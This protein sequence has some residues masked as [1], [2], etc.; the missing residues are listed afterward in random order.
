MSS[1][2]SYETQELIRVL[3]PSADFKSA[4]MI[5]D[6]EGRWDFPQFLFEA[7]APINRI[8]TCKYL[9]DMLGLDAS[10]QY[11]TAV[12]DLIGYVVQDGAFPGPGNP[13]VHLLWVET[14][15]TAFQLPKRWDWKDTSFIAT[16]ISADELDI[17]LLSKRAVQFLEDEV[18]DTENLWQPR[19][20][21]G[22]FSKA[23]AWLKETVE[24]NG[25][26]LT[27]RVRQVQASLTSTVLKAVSTNG[28]FYLKAPSVGANELEMTQALLRL[29]P[30][31]ILQVVA[32]S[33]EL[34]SFISKEFD[35]LLDTDDEEE[36]EA[37]GK[38][39][40]TALGDMQLASLKF[41]ED[42][43]ES[44]FPLLGIPQLIDEIENLEDNKHLDGSF[45]T[46]LREISPLLIAQ[47]RKLEVYNIPLVVTHGD[48]SVSNCG[49][50]KDGTKKMIL[51]DFMYSAI[52]HPFFDFHD[53]EMN[54]EGKDSYFSRWAQYET[55]ERCKEAFELVESLGWLPKVLASL[56]CVN[57]KDTQI[58]S[59]VLHIGV[60]GYWGCLRGGIRALP[61][62]NSD[63][64]IHSMPGGEGE[65]I[66]SNFSAPA[67]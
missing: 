44:G 17:H 40:L 8:S 15:D 30:E 35:E 47:L 28:T 55:L 14:R 12:T 20:Q 50:L 42:L 62:Q 13:Y 46:G 11:F 65:A 26:E 36:D 33:A 24:A 37:I 57:I 31:Y 54:D 48:F 3:V 61:R 4:L 29:M 7:Q 39:M 43:I 27:D 2:A 45:Q 60:H 64:D 63:S 9:S 21:L 58:R 23:S 53:V 1:E 38:S 18:C 22:W 56:K 10:E 59:D 19:H 67:Q 32:F 66:N 52:S 16:L 41:K 51:H 6:E 49:V 25:G 34:G 5:E